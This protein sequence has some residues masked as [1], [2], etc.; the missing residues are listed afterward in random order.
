MRVLAGVAGGY[1]EAK[2]MI[3]AQGVADDCCVAIRAARDGGEKSGVENEETAL[4]SF[5]ARPKWYW[6]V[7]HRP[8]Q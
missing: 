2:S 5:I 7:G 8:V 4:G 6:V 1:V 3:A